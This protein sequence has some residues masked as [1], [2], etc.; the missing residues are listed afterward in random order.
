MFRRQIQLAVNVG[1][2]VVPQ[3]QI[4]NNPFPMHTIELQ[5][6]K[7]LIRPNQDESTKGKN[8]IIGE[9]RSKQIK[10]V[11]ERKSPEAS[12]QN[13]T[14]G[15]CQVCTDRS[16]DRSDRSLWEFWKKFRKQQEERKAEFQ[17][18]LGQI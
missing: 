3:M 14:L 9:P 13:S 2:L 4:D 6:P 1:R 16:G 12:S 10:K 15:G 18:T 8:V 5:N 11:A 7:V 17:A